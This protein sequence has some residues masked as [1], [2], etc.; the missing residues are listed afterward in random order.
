MPSFVMA[1][2]DATISIMITRVEIEGFRTCDHTVFEPR[3]TVSALFGRNGSGKTT[4]LEAIYRVSKAAAGLRRV[5][6]DE[7]RL[8]PS[9]ASLDVELAE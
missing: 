9:R 1:A 6:V 7:L 3:G 4:I 2:R 5:L 8:L